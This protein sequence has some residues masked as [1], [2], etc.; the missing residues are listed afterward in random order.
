M[1]IFVICI[2][3]CCN[4]FS[5]WK[6]KKQ[7]QAHIAANRINSPL[8]KNKNN[9]NTSKINSPTKISNSNSKTSEIG[10]VY[11]PSWQ[12]EDGKLKLSKSNC[13]LTNPGRKLSIT[14]TDPD[15]VNREL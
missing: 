5:K 6:Q 2:C 15:G 13:L 11:Q 9:N 1:M 3:V 14:V 7:L 12:T 8:L 10:T 4:W